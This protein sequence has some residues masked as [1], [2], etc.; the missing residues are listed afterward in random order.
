[1][2]NDKIMDNNKIMDNDKTSTEAVWTGSHIAAAA[3]EQFQPNSNLLSLSHRP[4][5]IT[6]IVLV[7][8]II[9][10]LFVTVIILLSILLAK[11][12]IF[13]VVVAF[14]VKSVTDANLSLSCSVQV[15]FKWM[16]VTLE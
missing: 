8:A 1:M 13:N 3:V 5:R 10:R 7:I 14:F 9:I 11:I 4:I 12:I 16:K 6:Q 2:D 15:N